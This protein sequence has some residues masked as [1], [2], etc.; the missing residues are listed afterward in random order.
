MNVKQ[1]LYWFGMGY[2]MSLLGVLI[3]EL[4]MGVFS[5]TITVFA[6]LLLMGCFVLSLGVIAGLI[7]LVDVLPDLIVRE[8]ETG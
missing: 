4:N 5:W 8:K 6:P 3:L 1:I 7:F 2:F